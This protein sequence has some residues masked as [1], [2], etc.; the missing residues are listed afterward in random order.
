MFTIF[1]LLNYFLG[2]PINTFI[3]I[4]LTIGIY[5][6][7]IKY[8]YDVI[9]DN[10]IYT[11]TLLILMLIDIISIILIFF[12]FSDTSSNL[13]QVQSKNEKPSIILDTKEKTKSKKDRKKEVK[14]SDH[15]KNKSTNNKEEN[16]PTQTFI[17]S[18]NDKEIISLFDANKDVSIVTYK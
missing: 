4:L 11:I 16:L 3:L 1:N 7:L 18:G 9:H 17:T 14:N 2:K 6:G 12:Y 15:D 5:F 8:Y 13:I 10:T